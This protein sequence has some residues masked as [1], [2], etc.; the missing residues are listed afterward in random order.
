MGGLKEGNKEGL[1]ETQR[2]G[3]RKIWTISESFIRRVNILNYSRPV[4][5]LQK[6]EGI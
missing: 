3:V 5:L 6:N 4:V 1:K 2:S